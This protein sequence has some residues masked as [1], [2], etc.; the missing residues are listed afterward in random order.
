[1]RR[2]L[3]RNAR[4]EMVPRRRRLDDGSDW[5]E[6]LALLVGLG[7]GAL[8]LKGSGK[9]E[10]PAYHPLTFRRGIV[11]SA[12][13]APDGKTVIYS[14]AWEGKPLDLVYDASGKSAVAGDGT[15]GRGCAGDLGSRAKCCSPCTANRAMR[16]IYSGTLARVPLVGGA[17]RE[18]LD[19][20]EWADWSPDGTNVAVVHEVEGRKRLEF[21]LGK[22]LYQADGWI[23]NPRVRPDG[24]VVAFVDHPQPSDDGGAVAVV[25]LAREEDDAVRWMGQHSGPGVV[26][27]RQRNLVHGDAHGRRPV[28]VCDESVGEGAAAGASAGRVDDP[29]RRQGRKCAADARQ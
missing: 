24:K 2:A 27:G 7:S 5:S 28:A 26:G 3:P 12:R 19:D 25:D 10:F 14:A 11:H 16:F 6:L 4:E 9:T 13:F 29:R 23:G 21:P 22:M 15:Q 17:P 1:M 8:L 18:I 20:V